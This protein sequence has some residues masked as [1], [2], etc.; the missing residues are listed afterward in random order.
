MPTESEIEDIID[1]AIANTG[2]RKSLGHDNGESKQDF[3]ISAEQ[4]RL[5]SRNVVKQLQL[6]GLEIRPK[7]GAGRSD[8]MV[9]I[10]E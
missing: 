7:Q 5:L 1:Y 6:A 9:A 2:L 8:I 3:V 4:S 10:A